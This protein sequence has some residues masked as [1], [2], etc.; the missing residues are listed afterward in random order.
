MT[1]NL[2]PEDE[3]IKDVHVESRDNIQVQKD[4]L[5]WMPR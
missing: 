3:N 5:L 1:K 2:V 4:L